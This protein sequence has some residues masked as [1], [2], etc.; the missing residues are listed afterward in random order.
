M[1]RFALLLL[2]LLATSVLSF[3]QLQQE[4]QF[5]AW[6]Q[7][8]WQNGY[9]YE[10]EPVPNPLAQVF[11]VMCDDYAHGGVPGMQWEANVTNLGSDNIMLTRFNNIAG[12]NALYALTLYREAGWILQQTIDNPTSQWQS[13]NYAVWHIFDS[14]APLLDNAQ[15]WLTQAQNQAQMNFPGDNFDNVWILT[16]LNQHDTNPNGAQEFLYLGNSAPVGEGTDLQQQTPE[17]G[18]LVLLGSG[19]LA[20]LG[21]KF[22]N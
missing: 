20:M 6:N 14:Q 3:G 4:Y 21:R 15:F 5:L 22:W 12:S 1:R 18:T 11:A 19:L 17:P 2:M 9:P 8:D 7:G 10:I 16:P 13:M